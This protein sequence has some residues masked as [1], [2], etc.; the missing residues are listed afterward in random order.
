MFR[1]GKNCHQPQKYCKYDQSVY[2]VIGDAGINISDLTNKSK[3]NYA[4][5]L[6]DLEEPAT[7]EMVRA[8]E[9][10]D[11]VLKVRVVK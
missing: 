7:E 3:E 2:E 6:I 9:A 5:S 4:Y 11:G 8:L 10:I 1:C